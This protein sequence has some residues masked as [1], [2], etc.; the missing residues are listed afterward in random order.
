MNR[1]II[2]LITLLTCFNLSAQISFKTGDVEFETDLNRINAKGKIQYNDF[3]VEMAGSYNIQERKIEYMHT[4]LSMEPAEIYL[5]LEIG[6]ISGKPIDEVLNTY[7]IHKDK[8]W[9][10]IAKK[11]GIKP[12]S[13][14]FHAL[15]NR[16]HNHNNN[17]APH[18]K[19][20]KEKNKDKGKGKK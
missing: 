4:E 10:F 5:A 13:D 17:D 9:G 15:K 6:K 19:N 11:M 8:G 18:S 14:K 16:A 12:G 2:T 20:K 1:I 3:K 7:R